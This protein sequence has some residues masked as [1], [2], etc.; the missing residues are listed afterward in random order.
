MFYLVNLSARDI[1]HE[2][3]TRAGCVTSRRNRENTDLLRNDAYAQRVIV[4]GLER[5][6][7]DDLLQTDPWALHSYTAEAEA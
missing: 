7:I 3:N 2:S 6:E 5:D 4:A 1:E